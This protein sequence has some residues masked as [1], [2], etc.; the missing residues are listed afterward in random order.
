M[1]CN[2]LFNYEHCV[3]FWWISNFCVFWTKRRFDLIMDN[4]KRYCIFL[5]YDWV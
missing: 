3:T 4:C 5:V 1:S 2:V